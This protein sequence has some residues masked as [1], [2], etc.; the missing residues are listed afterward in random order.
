MWI[1]PSEP[2]GI[3]SLL[4]CTCPIPFAPCSSGRE[5]NYH[6]KTASSPNNLI[7][8]I[9]CIFLKYFFNYAFIFYRIHQYKEITV[10]TQPAPTPGANIDF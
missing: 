10:T 9:L 7:F 8:C 5:C 6:V 4:F 1:D 3:R 2:V